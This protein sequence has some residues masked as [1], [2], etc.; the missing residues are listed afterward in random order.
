MP[1]NTLTNKLF[2]HK[3][4]RKR[5]RTGVKVVQ[6][7]IAFPLLN[8]QICRQQNSPDPGLFFIC[9]ELYII[10]FQRK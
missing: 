9:E 6:K 1:S 4:M 2:K 5:R 3:Y 8:G 10:V 7:L